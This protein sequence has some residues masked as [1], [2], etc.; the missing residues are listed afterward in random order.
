[1]SGNNSLTEKEYRKLSLNFRKIASRF[2]NT[3][4]QE[5]NDNLERFLEFIENSPTIHYF[6]QENNKVDFDIEDIIKNRGYNE[7]YKLPIRTSEEIA[8]IYQLLKNIQ[9]S[10]R[11]YYRVAMGYNNGNKIQEAVDNFNNQVVKPLIDHIVS[12]LGEM[13]ID[14]GLDKKTNNQFNFNQFKGQFNHAEGQASIT[15][16][17]TYNEGNIE[18]LKVIGQNFVEAVLK[19]ATISPIDKEEMVE[20]LEAAIQEAESEKPKKVIIKSAIEKIKDV[21]EVITT[22]T[23]VY[24]LGSQLQAILQY[25][26]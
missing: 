26:I 21:K 10:E 3:D 16:N 22:G 17:Q 19:D 25:F 2:L 14:M 24:V 18:E 9:S 20:Y 4:F 8:F 12:Y 23:A 13:A 6:I 7:K 1:M 15:S 11:D 5:A